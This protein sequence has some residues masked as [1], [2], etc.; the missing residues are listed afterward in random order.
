MGVKRMSELSQ[1]IDRLNMKATALSRQARESKER[2]ITLCLPRI[3]MVHKKLREKADK[4]IQ[5]DR[6]DPQVLVEKT[7]RIYQGSQEEFT[8]R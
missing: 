8:D 5:V 2:W 3:E 6:L 7:V 1:S 4:M